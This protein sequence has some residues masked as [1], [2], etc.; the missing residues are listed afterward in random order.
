MVR[1]FRLKRLPASFKYAAR[2]VW[3]VLRTEQNL[4]IHF[5]TTLLVVALA[6]WLHV[7]LIEL[8]ILVL[9]VG[10]VLAS[11]ILNSVIE[12]FLDVIHPRH[13]PSVGRIKDVLAGSVLL[14]ALVAVVVGLL[15][16]VPHLVATV[17]GGAI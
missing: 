4:Q 16:F 11:E 10:F 3:H 6:L 15:I 2:G 13:H 5:L 7:S 9:T 14:S 12:D 1:D 8:A 17:R